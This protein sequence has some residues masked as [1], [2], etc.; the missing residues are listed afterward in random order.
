M[1]FLARS[2][3]GEA[4]TSL[5]LLV[6]RCSE[7][8][9][10]AL[11]L[12]SAV[13]LLWVIV[14]KPRS[15]S[16]Y[17]LTSSAGDP[18]ATSTVVNHNT[19]SLLDLSYF[20]LPRVNNP[21]AKIRFT[22]KQNWRFIAV[23][24]ALFLSLAGFYSLALATGIQQLTEHHEVPGSTTL[25]DKLT[26]GAFLTLQMAGKCY[27][28][29]CYALSHSFSSLQPPPRVTLL[30][31][32]FSL[33]ILA[34]SI[35]LFFLTPPPYTALSWLFTTYVC[36]SD[37]LVTLCRI[38]RAFREV[39]ELAEQ[40]A[41]KRSVKKCKLESF[42]LSRLA[43]IREIQR[44]QPLVPDP[45][46]S[47]A[48]A[49]NA[50]TIRVGG[51]GHGHTMGTPDST[52]TSEQ[53]QTTASVTLNRTTNT[54][55]PALPNHPTPAHQPQRSQARSL[56]SSESNNLVTVTTGQQRSVQDPDFNALGSGRTLA[57]SFYQ[58]EYNQMRALR[59][60][61]YALIAA[62][63]LADL[64]AMMALGLAHLAPAGSQTREAVFQIVGSFFGLHMSTKGWVVLQVR[65]A[66]VD[67]GGDL[68]AN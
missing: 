27:P 5:P 3:L 10:N 12:T 62:L 7:I 52:A 28:K 47:S 54:P 15:V 38:G 30:I 22:I 32:I 64:C 35:S 11:G 40:A 68:P 24:I 6:L 58:C 18:S 50:D 59:R 51:P 53:L 33:V 60:R 34:V 13:I 46:A 4:P 20:T 19:V 65:R 16:V 25:S 37:L 42:D 23:C 48:P 8:A 21:A 14:P 26:M 41:I 61:M 17:S 63:V 31:L 45:Y 36:M 2:L 55:H 44:S 29:S 66:V 49:L 67:A 57:M 9:I 1:L 56:Q 39:D 43:S